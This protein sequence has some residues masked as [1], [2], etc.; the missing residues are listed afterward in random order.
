MEKFSQEYIEL[1]ARKYKEGILSEKEKADFISWYSDLAANSELE[2]NVDI[3][4]TRNRIKDKIDAQLHLGA[5][6]SK[7]SL[8]PWRWKLAAAA[9]I[10][11]GSSI[12]FILTHRGEVQKADKEIILAKAD[13]QPGR[14][15][16]YLTLANGKTVKLDT[17][18]TGQA[19]ANNGPQKNLQNQL[20]YLPNNQQG[21]PETNSFNT[22]ITPA[23]GQYT[24]VLPDGSKVLLDAASRLTYPQ[25][26]SDT[27][28]RVV[29]EGQAYFEVAHENNRPFRVTAGAQEVT[30]LGTHFNI[31]AYKDESKVTTTLVQGL[32]RV[33][34]G[35]QFIVIKP[36]EQAVTDSA[37]KLVEVKNAH[38]NTEIAWVNGMIEFQDASIPKIMRQVARW[39]NIKVRYVGNQS[40]DLFSGGISR[41]SN[42]SSLLEILKSNDI[43]YVMK[44]DGNDKILEIGKL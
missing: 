32:V 43:P 13:A 6:V 11:I 17:V 37:Q 3:Y 8:R 5:D 27:V 26:F 31:N 29:L 42:L 30:V 19:V 44:Q 7:N 18:R 35:R 16:A 33:R 40:R 20:V 14:N 34:C 15:V 21:G 41:N 39:Y 22:L 28:R 1:L 38:V 10:L 12:F 24:V 36:G 2:G 23:G 4:E 25:R 9:S